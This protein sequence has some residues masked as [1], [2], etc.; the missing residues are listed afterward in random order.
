MTTRT[1]EGPRPLGDSTDLIEGCDLIL[2]VAGDRRLV[3]NASLGRQAS[4]HDG[5]TLTEQAFDAMLAARPGRAMTMS[6]GNYY[7]RAAHAQTTLDPGEQHDFALELAPGD[8][9]SEVDLWYPRADRLSLSLSV[10]GPGGIHAGPVAGGGKADVLLEGRVVARL[11][12][13]R[14]DPNNGDSQGSLFL[15]GD[16]PA[17]AWTLTVHGEAVGDGRLHAWVER[18]PAGPGRLRFAADD[19][20]PTCTVGT[21]CNGFRTIAV[22]AYDAHSTAR[23]PGRFSSAGPTRDGRTNRPGIGAPGVRVLSTRSTPRDRSPAPRYSRMSGTSMAAPYVAGTIALMFAAAR[24]P[25]TI[26]ETRDALFASVE[27][28]PD[29]LRLRFGAGFCAPAAAIARAAA[30]HG[31]PAAAPAIPTEPRRLVPITDREEITMDEFE[32]DTDQTDEAFDCDADSDAEQQA[33]DEAASAPLYEGFEETILPV[34]EGEEEGEE[35]AEED[36]GAEWQPEAQ[37]R[38]QRSGFGGGLSFQ[39]QIPL[40]GSGGL[41]LGIS[42]GARSSPFA[43][44]VPLSSPAAPKPYPP[45]PYPAQPYPAPP[46]AAQPYAAQPIAP[47]MPGEPPVTTALDLPPEPGDVAAAAQ[48]AADAGE[49][50]LAENETCPDCAA[51]ETEDQAALTEALALDTLE[52]SF[53]PAD[54]GECDGRYATERMMAEVACAARFGSSAEMLSALGEALGDGEADDSPTLIALFHALADRN[55]PQ[56]RLFGRSVRVLLRPGQPVGDV[57]PRR[58]DM[59]LRALPGA[60]LGAGVLRGIG[61]P[62][63]R[64]GCRGAGL[65]GRDRPVANDR[66]LR[67]CGGTVAGPTR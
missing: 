38:R 23:G 1:P 19:A 20:D 39:F 3:I 47:V 46:Y 25:L 55:L 14:D 21:I 45:A 34:M 13:R 40:G 60:G 6:C 59:L 42:I 4:Q 27:P 26:D 24:R 9:R 63:G 50:D 53:M 16:A 35:G 61:P 29:A 12:N 52:R 18:D 11:Y 56:P 51:R 7:A 67:P 2:R 66:R 36:P 8:R 57:A 28:V 43:L 48:A 54:A 37:G 30:I 15:H 58:G 5:L 49:F 32:D 62:C 33:A 31:P 10:R 44:S 22:A 17:G 64:R 65:P 41:G